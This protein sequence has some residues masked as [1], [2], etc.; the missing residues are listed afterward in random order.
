M[1][2][3]VPVVN[4]SVD[5][6]S[7]SSAAAVPIRRV[8]V[9]RAALKSAIRSAN[10]VVPAVAAFATTDEPRAAAED[11]AWALLNA[12]ELLFRN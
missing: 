12:K 8:A 4:R 3:P 6:A 1:F 7:K 11:L 2:E 10:D 9:A 5:V